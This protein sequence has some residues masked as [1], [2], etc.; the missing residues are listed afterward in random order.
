MHFLSAIVCAFSLALASQSVAGVQRT[1]V[2]TTGNDSNSV[3]N[4]SLASP[5]RS[6]ATALTVTASGGEVI[7]LD[8]GGYGAVAIGQSVTIAAPE[9]VY[10]GVSVSGGIGIQVGAPGIDVVLRGLSVVGQGGTVGVSFAAGNSLTLESCIVAN[11]STVGVDAAAPFGR[12]RIVGTTIRRNG[13]VGIDAHNGLAEIALDAVRVEGNGN[14]GLRLNDGV[15]AIVSNSRIDGNASG[16]GVYASSGTTSATISNTVVSA[17]GLAGVAAQPF[18]TGRVNLSFVGGAISHQQAD[19]L[20]ADAAFGTIADVT[21]SGAA[22]TDNGGNGVHASGAGARV[23]ASAN[24]IARNAL[25]G[26]LNESSTLLS[27]QD[28]VV[29]DNNGSAL[30]ADQTSG[31]IAPLAG[32]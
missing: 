10:A 19:G 8:S 15:R 31:T 26:L 12:A 27:R 17:N 21:I 5:C 4:C 16:L 29:V 3:A 22:V 23:S 14:L 9:G 25:F 13:D 28:N 6:F 1:F 30:P 20:R 11:M 24:T 2:S 32:I 18:G 7:A